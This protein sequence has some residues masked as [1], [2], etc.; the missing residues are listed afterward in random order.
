MRIAQFE[1]S[2]S[3]KGWSLYGYDRNEK[4]VPVAKG[5]LEKLI[6]VVDQDL[7]GIFWG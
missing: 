3:A 7:S 2:A 4:R 1:Y 5:N 6:K